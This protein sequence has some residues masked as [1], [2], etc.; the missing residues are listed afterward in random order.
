MQYGANPSG[1]KGY[2]VNR[3]PRQMGYGSTAHLSE[4]DIVAGKALAVPSGTAP[5]LKLYHVCTLLKF[6]VVNNTGSSVAITSLT[7]DALSGGSYITGS[8]TMDWGL[9]NSDMPRLDATKMG[10]SKAYTCT[11]NVV[12]NKGD[13]TTPEWSAITQTVADGESVDLYMIVAPFT[14]PAGGKMK[15]EITGSAG[16]CTL[17]KTMSKEIRFTAGSYN[18]ATISYSKPE[19]VLFAENFGTNAIGT[20]NIPKY[21]KSGLTTF[22]PEDKNNYSYG[23]GKN[24]SIQTAPYT[25]TAQTTSGAYVRF[26]NNNSMMAIKG[27]NLHGATSL[28]FSYRKDSANECETTLYYRFS[29]TSSWTEIASSSSIGLI[30]HDFTIDNPDGKT[31]DIQVKNRSE[32]KEEKYPVVDDWKLVALD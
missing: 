17:E 27:I 5:E 28:R 31:I 16:T 9:G 25:Y 21:D 3:T 6:T 15:L 12:E 1:T 2:T 13:E 18:T 30:S 14:I 24:A 22:Y 26:P 11:L 7:L 8:F 19:K 32:V 10:S 20:N 23:V 4:S 29:D